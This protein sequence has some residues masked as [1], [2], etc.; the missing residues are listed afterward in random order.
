[1]F[2]YHF[3]YE[4]LICVVDSND[5]AAMVANRLLDMY[6]TVDAKLFIGNFK[7]FLYFEILL[8]LFNSAFC[9]LSIY[10]VKLNYLVLSVV[11]YGEH[12]IV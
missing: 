6:P 11:I 8:N 3:Q 12:T 10:V 5:P 1:M 7:Y 4:V 2:F 9:N